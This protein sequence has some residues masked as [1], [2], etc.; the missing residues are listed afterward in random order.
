MHIQGLVNLVIE[1][2]PF[3]RRMC[4]VQNHL[5]VAFRIDP[6]YP[7]MG[8]YSTP[9]RVLYRPTSIQSARILE[10]GDH[11]S[12]ALVELANHVQGRVTLGGKKKSLSEGQL[13]LCQVIREGDPFTSVV[14]S[15]GPI[16]ST[17]LRGLSKEPLPDGEH[18][19]LLSRFLLAKNPSFLWEGW[20]FLERFL[21]GYKN[22]IEKIFVDD[23]ETQKAILSF[24]ENWAKVPSVT[25]SNPR[26][27]QS[28]LFESFDLEDAWNELSNP[29]IPLSHGGSLILDRTHAG[30]F[31]DLNKP[32]NHTNALRT[33][34]QGGIQVIKDIYLKNLSGLI[35]GDFLPLSSLKNKTDFLKSLRDF[36]LSDPNPVHIH[37]ISSLG[38]LEITRA[39]RDLSVLEEIRSTPTEEPVITRGDDERSILRMLSHRLYRNPKERCFR[40]KFPDKPSPCFLKALEVLKE[41]YAITIQSDG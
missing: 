11:G 31:Y 26:I 36:K 22:K 4:V 20:S 6:D 33:N 27:T 10:I 30:W 41:R 25:F 38:L 16:L 29:L 32:L 39:K 5:P 8:P 19:K 35:V 18:K 14:A 3:E 7:S 23:G 28:G 34:I 21:D 40:I 9:H 17:E 1:T 12:T 24:I 2:T 37:G 15:K 13:I